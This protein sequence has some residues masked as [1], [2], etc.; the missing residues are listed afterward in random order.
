MVRGRCEE[1]TITIREIN[2]HTCNNATEVAQ[3]AAPSCG[4]P[5]SATDN[6][7]LDKL[8]PINWPVLTPFTEQYQNVLRIEE[9]MGSKNVAI[10]RVE[11]LL[12]S[13]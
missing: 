1:S 13:L 2:Y 8:D 3:W 9:H 11:F 5:Q 6:M 4:R 7:A 10:I 12:R